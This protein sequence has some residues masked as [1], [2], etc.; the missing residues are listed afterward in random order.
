MVI[1]VNDRQ[2]LNLVLLQ[3]LGCCHQVGLLM[4]GHQVV[5]RHNLINR[6][7]EPTFE[8]QVTIGHDTYKSFVIINNGNTTNMILC[9][10]LKGLSNCRATWN[11]DGVVNHTILCPLD[12]SHLTCLVLNSH[13]LMNNTNS[14]LT[15]NGNSHL[16]LG[17]RVHGSSHKGN[18]QL[19][20][21]SE[22]S[23]QLYCL[24]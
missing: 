5:L 1:L 16:T 22:Q 6:T 10:D 9:H 2:L 13:V 11:G 14:S 24:G 17:H 19:N 15:G 21:T 7:V 23:F 18:V 8:T 3:Y 12:N 20:M 4:G